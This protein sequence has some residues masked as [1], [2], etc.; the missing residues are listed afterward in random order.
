MEI[1]TRF[2]WLKFTNLIPI[3][4]SVMDR[5]KSVTLKSER[6]SP[7]KFNREMVRVWEIATV[8]PFSIVHCDF[9]QV[10]V[11]LSFWCLSVALIVDYH[12][13]FLLP[14]PGSPAGTRHLSSGLNRLGEHSS[15][16]NCQTCSESETVSVEEQNKV[17]EG[18]EGERNGN[19]FLW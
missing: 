19:F 15:R 9:S 12:D 8:L 1:G 7:E 3:Y 5:E 2:L 17:A 16:T 6:C 13:A 11:H 4:M 10:N 14:A 18:Y